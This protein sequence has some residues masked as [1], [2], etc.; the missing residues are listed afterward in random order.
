MNPAHGVDPAQTQGAHSL[1][2][3]PE[4]EQIVPYNSDGWL[5]SAV[6][7]AILVHQMMIARFCL[8]FAGSEDRTVDLASCSR[9]TVSQRSP[10]GHVHVRSPEEGALLCLAVAVPYVH[11]VENRSLLDVHLR[12]LHSIGHIRWIVVEDVLLACTP[13][14]LGRTGHV[15][16]HCLRWHL[17]SIDQIVGTGQTVGSHHIHNHHSLHVAAGSM[18]SPGCRIGRSCRTAAAEDSRHCVVAPEPAGAGRSKP[19][20][21]PGKRI[22]RRPCCRSNGTRSGMFAIF[23]EERY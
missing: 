1:H 4:A 23:T 16:S 22:G 5:I 18:R 17:R 2:H 12:S 21:E 3:D 11:I 9:C 6:V 14:G 13:A 20:A 8:A 19:G 7:C 15:R 10:L